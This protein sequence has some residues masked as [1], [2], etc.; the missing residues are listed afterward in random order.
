M[1][2]SF[3]VNSRKLWKRDWLQGN[4]VHNMLSRRC[5]SPANADLFAFERSVHVN[6]DRQKH[7][8]K[9]KVRA[10]LLFLHLAY[11]PVSAS[12]VRALLPVFDWNDNWAPESRRPYNHHIWCYFLGLPPQVNSAREI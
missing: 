10:C 8:V 12:I 7:V 9:I 4:I 6:D 5:N 3:Q 1:F 11:V 2:T